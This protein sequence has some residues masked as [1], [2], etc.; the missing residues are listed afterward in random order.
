MK[1]INHITLFIL[2]AG[3]LTACSKS[4]TLSP[5]AQSFSKRNNYGLYDKES[6]VMEYQK[7]NHQMSRNRNC[8]KFRLQND[9]LSSYFACEFSENPSQGKEILVKIKTEGINFD[10][11]VEATFKVIKTDG[12]MVWLWSDKE[13]KGIIAR[14]E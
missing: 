6:P 8:T 13:N 3:L 1:L 10:E 2:A 4:D 7:F 5:E 12:E 9:N 14:I 11:N